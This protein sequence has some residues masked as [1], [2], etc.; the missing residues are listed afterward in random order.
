MGRWFGEGTPVTCQ[1]AWSFGICDL[2]RTGLKVLGTANLTLLFPQCS[3]LYAFSFCSRW[4]SWT[5]NLSHLWGPCH[6]LALWDH[7]LWGLQRFFQEEHLQQTCVSVQ[8]WQE[9]CHVPEAEEQVPVLPPAQVPPDGHEQEGWVGAQGSLCL[10]F[11]HPLICNYYTFQSFFH[12]ALY[13]TTYSRN[14]N[15]NLIGKA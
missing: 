8:S 10:P 3:N 4:S 13:S 2:P 11:T 5:T 12:Y 6:R 9:L 14:N 1:I 15:R 7:L